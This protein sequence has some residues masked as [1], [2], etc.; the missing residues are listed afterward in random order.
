MLGTVHPSASNA[1]SAHQLREIKVHGGRVTAAALSTKVGVLH[2]EARAQANV[3]SHHIKSRPQERGV[4]QDEKKRKSKETGGRARRE[5]LAAGAQKVVGAVH[6]KGCGILVKIGA[7]G[8]DLG[9]VRQL[10]VLQAQQGLFLCGG[11]RQNEWLTETK[12]RP[13]RQT[14]STEHRAASTQLHSTNKKRTK[15]DIP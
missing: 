15:K 7:L 12:N 10:F 2:A 11:E 9:R 3:T 1:A 8:G 14:S 6:G 13:E 5:H 4:R